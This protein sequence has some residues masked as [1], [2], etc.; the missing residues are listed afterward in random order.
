MDFPN[1]RETRK[2]NFYKL[3]EENLLAIKEAI[4]E[5]LSETYVKVKIDN[6]VSQDCLDFL[7]NKDYKC[8][9]HWD[10]ADCYI[11]VEW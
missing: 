11:S 3:F 1:A 8:E 7:R 10:L 5:T 6:R 2:N 9:L 4:Q